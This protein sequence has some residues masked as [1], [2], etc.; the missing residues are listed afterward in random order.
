MRGS[1]LYVIAGNPLNDAWQRDSALFRT[2]KAR[3]TGN[4]IRFLHISSNPIEAFDRW[5]ARVEKNNMPLEHFIVVN[6]NAFH[7]SYII[8]TLPRYFFIDPYG[9]FVTALAPPPAKAA[10]TLFTNIG[11]RL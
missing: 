7:S 4:N 11:P 6:W 1:Y 2:I 9:R 3:F 8:S 10:E 5:K